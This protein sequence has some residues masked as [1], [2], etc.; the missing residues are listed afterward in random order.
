MPTKARAA[1]RPARPAGLRARPW[2]GR[3][4]FLLS[5]IF[6][7]AFAPGCQ[8][9]GEQARPGGATMKIELTSTA[10][11]DGGAPE[12]RLAEEARAALGPW[13]RGACASLW[14]GARG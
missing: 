2:S 12:S 13:R 4:R 8:R 5:L 1:Q 11:R 10:F 9:G 7:L 3:T 6:L 14:A